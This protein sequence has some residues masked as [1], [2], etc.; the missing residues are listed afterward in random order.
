[1]TD[2]VEA[3]SSDNE[4]ELAEKLIEMT[5]VEKKADRLIQEFQTESDNEDEFAKAQSAVKQVQREEE[6]DPLNLL[7]QEKKLDLGREVSNSV[8]QNRVEQ[9]LA[10]EEIK[11][12]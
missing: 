10:S 4:S 12:E 11:T 1:M 7:E 2:D 6:G 9:V 3:I 5:F 8:V